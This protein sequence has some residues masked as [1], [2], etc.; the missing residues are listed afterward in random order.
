[1]KILYLNF[2]QGIPVLG[3]KGASVHVRE[4]VRAAA[5][6]GHEV[7]LVCARLGAGN[8]APPGA[9]VELAETRSSEAME[10][11]SGEFVIDRKASDSALASRE[12]AKLAYDR[13]IA[14]RVFYL[15]EARRFRPD[16]VYERHALFAAAGAQIATR[17]GCPR[18][19]EVNAPLA[20]EQ[21]RYRGLHLESAA[22]GLEAASFEATAGI[23]AVSERVKTYVESL[24]PGC[25]GRIQVL[26]NGVDVARFADGRALREQTREQ[27]NIAPET[28]VIGFIGSFKA[29]HG[30]DLLFDVYRDIAATRS[31]H[32]LAVGDGP[33]WAALHK[34]VIA[35]SC[36]GGVTLTGRVPHADIPALTA[37]IDIM[38]A[39]YAA[40]P[41]FY[42]SP[43]KVLE[44]LACGR[45]VVAP[46]IGQLTELVSHGETG[47]LYR[48]NDAQEC[49]RA[50]T[51]LLDNPPLR[52]KMGRAAQ[53]SMA[54]RGWE[55]IVE[56]VMER[57]KAAKA[58]VAA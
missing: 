13:S 26:A 49:R 38:V 11:I 35:A 28:P 1:M 45:P 7:L 22:R 15:L 33:C 47:L 2:D 20:E 5:T 40:A 55:R 30:T 10:A 17:L 43:L 23:I 16:F 44:A 34:K 41:D 25:A 6:L 50:I 12:V 53:A 18:I 36:C 32:L 42:F 8:E 4:F 57:A 48:P 54:A 27:L 21:K 14:Q 51:T 29:W 3:H 24:A 37:V 19:L 56:Q 31:L 46:R 39:P 58:G 9:V 52:M